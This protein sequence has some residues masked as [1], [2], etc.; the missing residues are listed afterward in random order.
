MASSRD[1]YLQYRCLE[2]GG[3]TW[4]PQP[5]SSTMYI[6]QH[7]VGNKEVKGITEE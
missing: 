2:G 4:K 1:E 3:G 5:P 6:Q 7:Y